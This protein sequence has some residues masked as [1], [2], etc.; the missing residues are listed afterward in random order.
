MNDND[1]I[2]LNELIS[3]IISDCSA[4]FFETLVSK[5]FED[6]KNQTVVKM[7]DVF[8]ASKSIKESLYNQLVEEI[9]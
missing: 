5:S 2:K 3:M 8:N 6:N 4:K 1:Y 9:S 7:I